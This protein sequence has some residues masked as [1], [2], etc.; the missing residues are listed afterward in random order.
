[1]SETRV[2][3]TPNMRHEH[4][5]VMKHILQIR[6]IFPFQMEYWVNGTSAITATGSSNKQKLLAYEQMYAE[7]KRITDLIH[8]VT[9]PIGADCYRVMREIDARLGTDKVERG[10]IKPYRP[11][12]FED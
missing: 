9:E 8:D 3:L 7:R 4:G 5:R 11:L 2:S 12:P 1:M 6:L 10:I